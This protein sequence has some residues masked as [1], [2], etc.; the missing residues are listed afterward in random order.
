MSQNL[1]ELRNQKTKLLLDAQKILTKQGVSAEERSTAQ[2]MIVDVE[3]IEQNIALEERIAKDT[4]ERAEQE[5]RAARPPRGQVGVSGD[6][7]RESEQRNF[8]HYM[9]TGEVRDLLV[10]SSGAPIVPQGFSTALTEA[11][12]NWGQ[13]AASVNNVRTA[14]GDPIRYPLAN[15]TGNQFSLLGEAQPVTEADPTV[16]NVLVSGG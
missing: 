14:T 8:V 15:D 9:R 7:E 5:Q 6:A 3:L 4:A 12:K 13:L 2:K 10:G 16:S 11:A 1:I